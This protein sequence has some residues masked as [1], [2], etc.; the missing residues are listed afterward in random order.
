[1]MIVKNLPTT[2]GFIISKGGITSNDL[3]SNGLKLK[4]SRVL[5]QILPGCSVIKCEPGH[6]RYPNMPVVIFPGNVGN[7]FGLVTTFR[8]LSSL[9]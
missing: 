9:H 8:R 5:G 2:I 1:M 7:E 6:K 3:L 4:M